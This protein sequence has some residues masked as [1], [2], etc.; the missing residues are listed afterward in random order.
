MA[1]LL[2]S[3]CW[4]TRFLAKWLVAFLLAVIAGTVLGAFTHKRPALRPT[5]A[6]K[7]T[8]Q[9]VQ[10]KLEA[11]EVYTDGTEALIPATLTT[12]GVG[13]RWVYESAQPNLSTDPKNLT[14]LS[15]FPGDRLWLRFGWQKYHQDILINPW[16]QSVLTYTAKF[17]LGRPNPHPVGQKAA[18]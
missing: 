18:H 8:P 16:R 11:F 7:P 14:S 6:A 9:R 1:S 12:G 2:T 3:T 5:V 15:R 13:D 10:A 17:D 4:P